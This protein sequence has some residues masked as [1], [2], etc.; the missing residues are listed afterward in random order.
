MAYDLFDGHSLVPDAEELEG[1]LKYA[2]DQEDW[3]VDYFSYLRCCSLEED[4]L[5]QPW[6]RK[7]GE[8]CNFHIRG[9]MLLSSPL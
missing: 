8:P 4:D 7:K 2:K 9:Q 5:C 3:V 1:L 6:D